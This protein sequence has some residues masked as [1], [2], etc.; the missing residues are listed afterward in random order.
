MDNTK[1]GM[2]ERRNPE[3]IDTKFGVGDYV[4][5]IKPWM[6]KFI[7]IAPVGGVPAYR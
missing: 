3:P 2:S 1:I 7:R 4:G 5:D 6:T